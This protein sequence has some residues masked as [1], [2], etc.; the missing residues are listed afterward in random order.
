MNRHRTGKDRGAT[1]II[2][3]IVIAFLLAVGILVLYI[4][5]TGP[6]VAGNM[7]LQEQAFNAAEAGFDNA[8]TQIEGSYVGAGWTNFEGHYITQPTGV[9]DPLDVSYFRKLTDEEL[10]AAVS[11]SDPNMIFYKIPYVTTQSGTLDARYTYTAFLIDD[12][13]GGG[14][15]DPFDALLICIGTVQTGDSVTT[16]RLEIG[17]AVQLPGG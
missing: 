15:P 16:S 6:E 5:G 1:L 14:D 8:W 11:A 7:R 2:L 17:L 13:A 3:I 12:E 10:L 9:S 4:T